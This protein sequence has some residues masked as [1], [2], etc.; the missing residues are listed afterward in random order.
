VCDRRRRRCL[1]CGRHRKGRDRRRLPDRLRITILTDNEPDQDRVDTRTMKG[2]WICSA[3]PS[4]AASLYA[5][6]KT[7][8][9]EPGTPQAWPPPSC[10]PIKWLQTASPP[11]VAKAVARGLPAGRSRGLRKSFEGVRE[12]PI[13][14]TDFMR[15][16]AIGETMQLSSWPRPDSRCKPETSSSYAT[17]NQPSRRA[18]YSAVSHLRPAC[19]M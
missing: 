3:V 19:F 5:S 15:P 14:P 8:E 18:L 11:D 7:P 1:V 16:G 6:P 9:E 12:T 4:R 2:K 10:A 13:S 17:W